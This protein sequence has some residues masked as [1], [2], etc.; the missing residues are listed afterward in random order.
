MLDLNFSSILVKKGTI[1]IIHV[2]DIRVLFFYRRQSFPGLPFYERRKKTDCFVLYNAKK[3]V[4]FDHIWRQQ[5]CHLVRL[6]NKVP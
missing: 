6:K 4:V 1:P 2:L 3:I 5:W